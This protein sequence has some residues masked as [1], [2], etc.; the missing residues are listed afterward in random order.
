MLLVYATTDLLLLRL[1]VY[2]RLDLPLLLMVF[3][4]LLPYDAQDNTPNAVFSQVLGFS[5][6]VFFFPFLSFPFSLSFLFFFPIDLSLTCVC[7][8]TGTTYI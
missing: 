1:M 4:V 5:S 8:V 6:M 3:S 2:F 7:V